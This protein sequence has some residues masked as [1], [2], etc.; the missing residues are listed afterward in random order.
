[1]SI[2]AGAFMILG[3]LAAILAGI[4]VVRFPTSYA[5]FHAAGVAS[6][7]ALLVASV[8]AWIELGFGDGAYLVIGAGA[9]TL[10]MPVGVH[11]LFRAVHRTAD[12]END[13]LVI[14][15]LAAPEQRAAE[16]R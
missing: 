16:G 7:V 6:P 5:R 1:M 8:G 13:H 3:S 11:L 4:G 14:D 12:H 15:D 2:I 9:M 10:T